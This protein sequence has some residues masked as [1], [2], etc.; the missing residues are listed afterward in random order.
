MVFHVKEILHGTLFANIMLMLT[1]MM[2]N[3]DI[4]RFENS[5]ISNQ[6]ASEKSADQDPHCFQYA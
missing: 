3:L 2:L 5:A 4:S 1:I 6:L